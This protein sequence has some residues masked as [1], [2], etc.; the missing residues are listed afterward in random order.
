M[1]I[2][3]N[4]LMMMPKP[5]YY[6]NVANV[7]LFQPDASCWG[8]PFVTQGV[9]TAAGQGRTKAKHACPFHEALQEYKYSERH[10][11]CIIS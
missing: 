8:P 9:P 2:L 10:L 11:F 1:P 3:H 4:A 7:A 5:S 6:V